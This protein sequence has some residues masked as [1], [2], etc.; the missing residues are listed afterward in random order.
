MEQHTHTHAHDETDASS[1]KDAA[2]GHGMLVIG[3]TGTFFYHLPMFMSPHD[4]QVILEGRLSQQGADPQTIYTQDR[5]AN[6]K[7]RVYTFA[8]APFVLPDLFPPAGPLKTVRGDL[9]RGHFEAPPEYPAAPFRLGKNVTVNVS[10]VVFQRKLLPPAAAPDHLE[11]LLFG[12]S[13][14]LFLA[15]LITRQSDFDQIVSADVTGRQFTDDELRHGVRV[16]FSDRVNVVAQRLKEG[17]AV[18]GSARIA[19]RQAVL[20]V[21]PRVEFY[22]SERDLT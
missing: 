4:Y 7:T 8:P 14:E 3:V 20:Q 19:D 13:G 16:R 10:E 1:D 17:K 11:Y 5:K 6:P 2:A 22:F 9:F 15:H 12:K 18:S 21:T